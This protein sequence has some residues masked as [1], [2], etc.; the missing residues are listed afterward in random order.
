MIVGWFVTGSV[1]CGIGVILGA[2]GAHWLKDRLVADMLV[3]F[4]TGIRYHFI[5]AFGLFAVAW[6]LSRWPSSWVGAAGWFFLVGIVLFS[7]SLYLLALTGERWLG[8]ITPIGG[9]ILILGWMVLA[10]GVFRGVS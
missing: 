2:F 6:A 3:V 8:M 10:T 4:E 7:G 5:H 1:L 9:M